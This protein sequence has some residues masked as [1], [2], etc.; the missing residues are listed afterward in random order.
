MAVGPHAPVGGKGRRSVHPCQ[1]PI[2][3]LGLLLS[4]FS[5]FCPQILDS[6]FML[7]D[8]LRGRWEVTSVFI[9]SKNAVEKRLHEREKLFLYICRSPIQGK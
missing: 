9:M 8:L 2:K 6:E 3:S 1:V 7:D 4:L 5:S